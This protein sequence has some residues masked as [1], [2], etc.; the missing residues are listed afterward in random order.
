VTS[1]VSAG[2]LTRTRLPTVTSDV[3]SPGRW[4]IADSGRASSSSVT[5]HGN[6]ETVTR[7]SASS[8]E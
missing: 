6:T 7:P 1:A 2:S 8:V 5:S 3:I 4:F